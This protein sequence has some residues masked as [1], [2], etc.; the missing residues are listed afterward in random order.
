MKSKKS[1]TTKTKNS[2]FYGI[3][4]VVIIVALAA[5]IYF[6]VLPST[7]V[8]QMLGITNY[9]QLE[10]AASRDTMFEEQRRPHRETYMLCDNTNVSTF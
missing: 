5:G 2:L 6:F 7:P 3:A 10:Q 9:N 8:G 4:A 1:S